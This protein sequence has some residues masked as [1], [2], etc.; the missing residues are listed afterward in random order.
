ML[1]TTSY[2]LKMKF[3]ELTTKSETELKKLL[4]DLRQEG[5]D[6]KMKI[7]LQ[8]SKQSHKLTAI[9]KDI[10]RIMTYLAK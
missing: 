9:K 6:L 3:K 10:A 5:H 8:E 7:R 1:L 4:A 2:I